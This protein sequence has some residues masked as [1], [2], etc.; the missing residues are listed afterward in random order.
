L[1][2]EQLGL[3]LV[4]TAPSAMDPYLMSVLR[5]ELGRRELAAVELPSGAGHHAG[6]LA[7][8]GVQAAMLFVRSKGGISHH[9]DEE[10]S[11]DDVAAGVDVLAAAVARLAG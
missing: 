5:E 3:D 11:A 10:S 1:L 6:V 7:A 8:V 2:L 9:P 4:A